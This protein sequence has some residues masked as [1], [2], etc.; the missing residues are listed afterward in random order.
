MA[1]VRGVDRR[2]LRRPFG[3]AAEVPSPPDRSDERIGLSRGSRDVRRAPRVLIAA[4]L[5]MIPTTSFAET[6][7]LLDVSAS[8]ERK[9][10]KGRV[11]CDVELE[12]PAARIAWADVLVTSAPDFAPPLRSRIGM[13]D[14]RARTE[15]RV[16]LPVAFVATSL[17]R[18]TVAMRARAVVCQPAAAGAPETCLPATKD[19]SAEI[20]VGT[21]IEH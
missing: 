1:L 9:A 21:D 14:A 15:H 7:V 17:G 5:L 3:R 19:V 12:T 10:T 18:G 2:N 8:C 16:R 6:K 20:I 4:S 13:A 11:L